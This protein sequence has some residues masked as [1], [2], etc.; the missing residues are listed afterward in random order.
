MAPKPACRSRGS[1][2]GS[3]TS[4]RW[5]LANFAHDVTA[6]FFL[7]CSIQDFK[8]SFRMFLFISVSWYTVC[9]LSS[10]FLAFGALKKSRFSLIPW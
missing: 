10:C 8:V 2:L 3:T 4:C 9:I 5:V 7:K 6:V 1:S